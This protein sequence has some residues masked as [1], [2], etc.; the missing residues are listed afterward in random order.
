MIGANCSPDI[1]SV[2]NPAPGVEG[3]V[4]TGVLKLPITIY[5]V[6]ALGLW[7]NRKSQS[8]TSW[9]RATKSLCN[10]G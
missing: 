8:V 7:I 3:A 10:Q 9:K 5:I 6:K 2:L 4:T 1:P